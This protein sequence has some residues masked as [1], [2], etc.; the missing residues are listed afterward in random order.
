MSISCGD[1]HQQISGNSTAWRKCG[2][3]NDWIMYENFCMPTIQSYH[4]DTNFCNG[5]GGQGEWKVRT[6]SYQQSEEAF[7]KGGGNSVT[8]LQKAIKGTP[9]QI[10][11]S[12]DASRDYY[13]QTEW[14]RDAGII[15]RPI[16]VYNTEGNKDMGPLYAPGDDGK[17]LFLWQGWF[18]KVLSQGGHEFPSCDYDDW[19][20]YNYQKSGTCCY[21]DYASC[22]I[23]GGTNVA[24]MRDTFAA[25]RD[26]EGDIACCFNDLVCEPGREE[27]DRRFAMPGE[28]GMNIQTW[29]HDNKCFRSGQDDDMRTCNPESRNLGGS[30]CRNVIEPYCTGEKLFPGVDKWETAWG[31]TP[32]DVNR[33]DFYGGKARP[34]QIN[35]PCRK[36]LMRQING[37]DMQACNGDWGNF[38]ISIGNV[39][40]GGL[41]WAQKMITKLFEVYHKEYRSPLLGPNED[42]LEASHSVHGFLYDLCKKYP[43]LCVSSLKKM[44][45]EVT[46]KDVVENPIANRWCGCYMKE[47][48]YSKYSNS[49]MIEKECT[50]FCA[51]NEV[52]PLVDEGNNIK[53]CQ[54]NICV[55]NDT[56][57]DMVSSEGD[58][59]F[60]NLC[61]K[62]GENR[63]SD[64]THGWSIP[65]SKGITTN[66]RHTNRSSEC[67][68]KIE[69]T[70]IELTNEKVKGLNLSSKCGG[71]SCSDT[72][73][74]P[75]ACSSSEREHLPVTDIPTVIKQAKNKKFKKILLSFLVLIIIL[76]GV[77]IL[78]GRV[79][80]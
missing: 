75:I 23:T 49:F 50:P 11:A 76:I 65:N 57:I 24:C 47:E 51:R 30:Y 35:G 27:A 61:Q 7:I 48:E 1:R 14:M 26:V 73:G 58:V 60:N 59:N 79:K 31:D 34:I 44:C 53:Y 10:Q 78:F 41:L 22:G 69:D 52:I 39:N 64:E 20:M 9:E 46:E 6:P 5:L 55:I 77:Y 42:G 21:Q 72:N 63:V 29:Q 56:I 54:Q 12:E 4:H 18:N 62:C 15:G 36:L 67:L 2:T 71:T 16:S 37:I 45:S 43:A 80:N 32:V 70:N 3:Y 17:P 8:D 74:N 19:H 38:T 25:N 28:D 68:C 13:H 66:T 33:T 40:L